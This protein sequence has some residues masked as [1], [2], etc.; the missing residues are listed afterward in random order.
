MDNFLKEYKQDISSHESSV[1][2][3]SASSIS[4]SSTSKNILFISIGQ[5][6]MYQDRI[7]NL[8]MEIDNLIFNARVNFQ[9]VLGK[10]DVRHNCE[11][12]EVSERI[13]YTFKAYFQYTN[14]GCNLFHN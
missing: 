4:V 8:D 9:D 1:S 13:Q 11:G 14:P 10:V 3:V 7:D 12:Q 2:H 6:Y 5:R